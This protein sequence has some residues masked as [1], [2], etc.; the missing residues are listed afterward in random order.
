MNW[1]KRAKVCKLQA[2]ADSTFE[3]HPIGGVQVIDESGELIHLNSHPKTDWVK[4]LALANVEIQKEY[5][6]INA[7]AIARRSN[8]IPYKKPPENNV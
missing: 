7:A 4:E 8:R 5:A 3:N 1:R 6:A 2:W